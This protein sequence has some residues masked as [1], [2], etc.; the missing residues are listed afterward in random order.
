VKGTSS[1][2]CFASGKRRLRERGRR[3]LFCCLSGGRRN[4]VPIPLNGGL[5]GSGPWSRPLCLGSGG[6]GEGEQDLLAS[7]SSL[8]PLGCRRSLEGC[9]TVN[10]IAP[11]SSAGPGPR[12]TPDRLNGLLRL[13]ALGR[14]P[15][16]PRS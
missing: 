8:S 14:P 9:Q 3:P 11:T 4:V 1:K 5:R 15:A 7:G 16:Q 2:C 10:V 13:A 12:V 6:S